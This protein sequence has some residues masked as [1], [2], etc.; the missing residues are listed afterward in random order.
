MR[1]KLYKGSKVPFTINLSKVGDFSMSQYDFEI[2]Y[3]CTKSKVVLVKKA[4]AMRIDD[5]NY[6]FIVDTALVDMGKLRLAVRAMVPD[7][8][9]EELVRPEIIDEIDT[10]C[11]VVDTV[12]PKQ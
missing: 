7:S 1:I 10:N 11:D 3:Y 5:D 12:V 8:R 6:L 9:F 4:Q 2:F